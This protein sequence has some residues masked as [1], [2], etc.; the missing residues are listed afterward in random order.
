MRAMV[1]HAVRGRP[2]VHEVADPTVPG[3][4]RGGPR[5]GHRVVPQ[6]LARVGGPRRH[7]VPARAGSRAGRRGRRG[8]RGCRPVGGRRPRDRPVRLRLRSLR[9]VPGRR[10]RRC[11]P[12]SSSP[13]F[14]H[15]GSF[16]EHVALHAADTNLVGL[17][18]RST[19][20]PPPASAAGSPRRTAPSSAAPA[21]AEGEWVT[22]VGAGGVG[23][24]TVMIARALGCSGDRGGPQPARHS[25]LAADLGAEPRAARRRLGRPGRRRRPHGRRQPRRGRRRG[26]RADLRRRDPQPPP[27]RTPRAGRTAPAGRWSP[28]GADGSGD[29]LGARPAGQP[30]DGR[31]RLP[32]HA[33]PRRAR[34]AP[35]RISW[36][37]APSGSRRPRR[38]CPPSTG[39]PRPASR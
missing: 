12:T 34:P 9:V 39:R 18:E 14:T 35:A 32:G 33:R 28:A 37:S 20:R 36:S 5:D 21:S 17:P 24:S 10:T 13:G 22:V 15:W 2:E 26:Q 31:G 38:S 25:R 29:R 23:L 16:A 4:R 27:P 3:R 19:S 1:I 7:R 6:R 11:A 8:R 30:R